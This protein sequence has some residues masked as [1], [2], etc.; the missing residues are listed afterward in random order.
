VEVT[1][2]FDT[3]FTE[4][5]LSEGFVDELLSQSISRIPLGFVRFFTWLRIVRCVVLL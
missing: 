5:F 4:C 2:I 3:L 1:F